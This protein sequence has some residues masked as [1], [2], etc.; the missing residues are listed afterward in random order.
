MEKQQLKFVDMTYL[1]SF[2]QHDDIVRTQI[3]ESTQKRKYNQKESQPKRRKSNSK[4]V[5]LPS[6]VTILTPTIRDRIPFNFYIEALFKRKGV[7][8]AFDTPYYKYFPF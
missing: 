4:K 2:E 6:V 1:F 5:L 3:L 7:I 8:S